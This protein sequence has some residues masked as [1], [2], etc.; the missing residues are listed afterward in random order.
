M[1]SLFKILLAFSILLCVS[2]S[3]GQEEA[4]FDDFDDVDFSE[5]VDQEE[6]VLDDP[7][8]EEGEI[9]DQIEELNRFSEEQGSLKTFIY[10]ERGRKSPFKKPNG[11]NLEL[12]EAEKEQAKTSGLEGYDLESFQVTAVLWDIKFPKA[13]IKSPNNEIFQV[14]E[15]SK[16]GR[17]SG[18]V[19]KIREGEVV[20]IESTTPNGESG[21]KFYKTQV[22]KLGR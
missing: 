15:G 1:E 3:M 6:P 11:V 4:T 16:I 8:L 7:L 17:N 13:L 22:L 2:T 14:E 21:R 10:S 19:A 20:V 9:L 12:S 18:Y 5:S